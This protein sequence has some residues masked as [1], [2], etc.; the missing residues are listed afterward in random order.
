MIGNQANLVNAPNNAYPIQTII[1][2]EIIGSA[3]LMSVIYVVVYKGL[4]RFGGIAV[5]GI[6]GLDIFLFGVYIWRFNE[7]CPL[8]GT[9]TC[10]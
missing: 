3:L 10:I 4:K 2:V 9:G 6:V 1:G 5:G 8:F 7:S